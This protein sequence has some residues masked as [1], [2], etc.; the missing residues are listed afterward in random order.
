MGD[1]FIDLY[2]YFFSYVNTEIGYN[3]LISVKSGFK[4][5][6]LFMKHKQIVYKS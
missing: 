6:I 4:I 5:K 3:N 1:R 2:S